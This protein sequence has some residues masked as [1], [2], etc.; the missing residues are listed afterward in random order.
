MEG[1]AVYLDEGSD[2]LGSQPRLVDLAL[3]AYDESQ[4]SLGTGIYAEDVGL[5][6]TS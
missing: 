2:S 5:T 6:A 1:L 4:A 3:I